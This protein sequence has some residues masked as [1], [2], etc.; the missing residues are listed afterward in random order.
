MPRHKWSKPYHYS[1]YLSELD[2][3]EIPEWEP[4]EELNVGKGSFSGAGQAW[5]VRDTANGMLCLQSYAT[6]VSMY[7]GGGE[8]RELGKWT[9]TTSRHQAAFR[10]WASRQAG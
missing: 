4:V 3:P 1:E 9:R 8:V 7:V 10:C 6:I 2:N 5:V